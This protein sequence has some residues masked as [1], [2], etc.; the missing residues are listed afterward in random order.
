MSVLSYLWAALRRGS[1]AHLPVPADDEFIGGE[2][3]EPHRTA[4]VQLLR[5]DAHLRPESELE[6]VRKARGGVAVDA[7]RIDPAQEELR[8]PVVGGDDRLAVMGGVLVDPTDRLAHVLHNFDGELHRKIFREIVLLAGGAHEGCVAARPFIPHELHAL[9][10]QGR[11]QV[12]KVLAREGVVHDKALA[13]VAHADALR[14][15]VQEDGLCHCKV[16]A[17]FHIAPACFG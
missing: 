4:R 5:G 14:L 15:G 12:S 9:L 7:R 10:P 13:G 3:S 1:A 17:L 16:G 2:L 6:P 8:R 11:K